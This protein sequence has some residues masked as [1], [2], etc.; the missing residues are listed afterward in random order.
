MACS[1][2]SGDE[3]EELLTPNKFMGMPFFRH[4]VC[5]DFVVVLFLLGGGPY[6]ETR[7]QIVWT[8]FEALESCLVDLSPSTPAGAP[9]QE[10]ESSLQIHMGTLSKWNLAP[11]MAVFFR[12]NSRICPYLPVWP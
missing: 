10:A 11:R 2:T 1:H 6:F 8:V 4:A 3:P 9:Y 12:S 5:L 7:P